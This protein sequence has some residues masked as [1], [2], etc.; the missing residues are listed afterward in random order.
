MNYEDINYNEILISGVINNI[1]DTNDMY[2]K[3]SM[4]SKKYTTNEN[5]NV[6]VS[7]NVSRELYNIYKDY[8]Y[9][10]N[11]VFVKGYLNSY[12]D[13]NRNIKC[14]ISVID[15]SNNP[16]DIIKGRKEPHIRYDPDGVEVWNGKRLES[17]P[18]TEEEQQEL[19]NLIDEITNERNEC[20]M[21]EEI[22][23]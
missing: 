4:V 22:K 15:I 11:K 10:D 12:I 7:L 1:T 19:Q 20:N 17:E 14:F 8:F 9:K 16:D 6:Y 5:K 21:L 23:N 18:L 2:I 13:K 3:F